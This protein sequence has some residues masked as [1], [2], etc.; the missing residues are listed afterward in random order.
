MSEKAKGSGRAFAQDGRQP[1]AMTPVEQRG[2]EPM[3]MTPLPSNSPQ[4]QATTGTAAPSSS[5]QPS[6]SPQISNQKK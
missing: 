1:L 5:G 3:A 6:V 2:R 4:Q